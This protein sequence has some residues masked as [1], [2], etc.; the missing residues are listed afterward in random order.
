LIW[1][2]N[3]VSPFDNTRKTSPKLS[4]GWVQI[5]VE[6]V[7]RE[8]RRV[9][10]NRCSIVDLKM[11]GRLQRS[12]FYFLPYIIGFSSALWPES[13]RRVSWGFEI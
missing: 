12:D 8:W 3:F 11:M 4:I 5:W 7:R 13:N 2:S 9:A 10:V 1:E 6:F